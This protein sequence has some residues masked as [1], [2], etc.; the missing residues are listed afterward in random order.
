MIYKFII[1][2]ILSTTLLFAQSVKLETFIDVDKCGIVLNHTTH[3]TCFNTTKNGPDA[4]WY[5]LDG[6]KVDVVNLTSRPSFKKDPLLPTKYQIH[7]KLYE[8]NGQSLDQGHSAEDGSFDYS[9]EILADIYF[10]SNMTPQYHYLN[11]YYWFKAEQFSRHLAVKY[12]SVNVI[13]KMLYDDDKFL[14]KTGYLSQGVPTRYIKIIYNNEAEVIH[15]FE[16][17][18]SNQKLL[19]DKLIHHEIKCTDISLEHL[20]F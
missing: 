3:T 15:C 13:N 18:N 5:S 10:S 7:Y 19:Y 1:G 6:S 16:F 14:T 11:A 17:K 2:C 12:G 20:I 9:S 8:K 4:T